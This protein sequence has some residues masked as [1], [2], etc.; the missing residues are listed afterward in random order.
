MRKIGNLDF[1][2]AKDKYVFRFFGGILGCRSLEDKLQADQRVWSSRVPWSVAN[3]GRHEG[4]TGELQDQHAAD[5]CSV[6][7]GNQGQALGDDGRQGINTFSLQKV[8]KRAAC[9]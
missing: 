4:Q 1:I 8:Q 2:I 5:Q 6:Y 9:F 3:C 7:T